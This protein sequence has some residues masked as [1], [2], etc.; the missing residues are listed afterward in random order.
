MGLGT[1]CVTWPESNGICRDFPIRTRDLNAQILYSEASGSE[2]SQLN[3]K[4]WRDLL[5]DI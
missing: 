5:D 1:E 4:D 3:Q 2:Q